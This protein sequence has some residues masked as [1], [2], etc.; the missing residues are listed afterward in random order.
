MPAKLIFK[1]TFLNNGKIYEIFANK[2]SQSG[3]FGFIEIEEFIFDRSSSLVIDPSEDRLAKEFNG[4]KRSYI[5]MHSVIRIDEVEKKGV[6]KIS[7]A[8]EN[9]NV[10]APFPN[11]TIIPPHENNP[12]D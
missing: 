4:I 2:V 11:S 6:A 12:S 1:I 3:L 9:G 7:N 10:I 8:P 5:P